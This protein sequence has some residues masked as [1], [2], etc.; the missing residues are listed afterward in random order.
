MG[1][2]AWARHPAGAVHVT[3][4]TGCA[5]TPVAASAISQG[6]TM[7]RRTDMVRVYVVRWMVEGARV[8]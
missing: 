7:A 4:A 5:E 6:M 1:C 3:P 2:G 8:K